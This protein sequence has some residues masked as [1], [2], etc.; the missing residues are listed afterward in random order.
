MNK[1][2]AVIAVVAVVLLIC[3]AVFFFTGP[4]NK[5]QTKGDY[6]TFSDSDGNEVSLSEKPQKVAV[7]FSS[8]CDAWQLSGGET[9]VTVGESIEREIVKETTLTVDSGA[10]KQINT[11]L[12]LSYKPDFVIYSSD[13][14]AQKETAQVLQSVGIPCAGMRLDSFEDYLTCLKIFCQINST[15]ENYTLYGENVKKQ[16]DALKEKVSSL[17]QTPK[18]L[19]LRSGSTPSTLKAKNSDDNFAAKM[20]VELGCV[21]IADTAEVLLDGLSKEIILKENPGLIFVSPMGDEAAAKKNA[22]SVLSGEGFESLTGEIIFLPKELFHFKPCENWYE[23]YLY[24]AKII[25]Q[26]EEF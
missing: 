19:F 21:N 10:G 13:I 24:L 7:L 18:V 3:G 8:L 25:Y 14:P 23:A 6:Y 5:S 12:L 17:N 2:T 11:E 4:L 1:K 16:I 9:Y 20:L 15:E 22:L 26:G